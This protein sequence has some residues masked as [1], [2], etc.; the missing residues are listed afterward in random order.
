MG[1]CRHLDF[2]SVKLIL[3]F[4]PPELRANTSC[5]S[6][7][8]NLCSFVTAATGDYYTSLPVV[9]L[10][11]GE[12]P[13]LQSGDLSSNCCSAE[14]GSHFA[15]PSLDFSICELEITLS[16]L[17]GSLENC[18]SDGECLP[19]LTPCQAQHRALG[20]HSLLY[21]SQPSGQAGVAISFG[22]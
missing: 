4:G 3:C 17:Q 6:T 19:G 20:M 22:Q 18:Y 21:T 16:R 11:A 13:K 12:C 14:R 1:P 2:S 5:H 9:V 15:T 8:P 7:L 10:G